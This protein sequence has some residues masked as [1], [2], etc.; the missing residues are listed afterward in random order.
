MKGGQKYVLSLSDNITLFRMRA[1][2]K[3]QN[4]VTD[5]S[6]VNAHNQGS[7]T[8]LVFYANGNFFGYNGAGVNSITTF[9]PTEDIWFD[10]TVQ[11]T[12]PSQV[13]FEI[14]DTPSTY[15]P[16]N[17][18]TYTIDLDGTRYGGTL[19][20]VS[21]V[22][23]VDRIMALIADS[24]ISE[25]STS[26]SGKYRFG[27]S[28]PGIKRVADADILGNLLCSSYPNATALATYRNSLGASV[29]HNTDGVYI[30]DPEYA[31]ATVA[32]FKA[33]KGDVQLVY[34][35]ATPITVQLAPTQVKSL[36]GSNNIFADC[37]DINNV[38][39]VRNLNITI[40]DLLSRING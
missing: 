25:S 34:E 3:F 28:F 9:Q 29:S 16:Y 19:D 33:A 1:F 39:Y 35:L 40:N 27:I 31:T 17:G 24:S 14:G 36:L 7:G 18:A 30:Y 32:E 2:D 15:E 5:A 10:M 6:I 4:L 22:L 8:G 38:E 26:Q 20:V 13:M 12:S 11:T 21:G 37:G 23:T